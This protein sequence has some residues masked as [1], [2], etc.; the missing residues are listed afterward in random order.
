L[1]VVSGGGSQQLSDEELGN[2]ANGEFAMVSG[3]SGNTASSV[4]SVAS[5]G[6]NRTAEGDFDWVA[7]S[8]FEDE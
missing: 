6:R 7:G 1:A 4:R 2:T 3:G 5:G 8:L